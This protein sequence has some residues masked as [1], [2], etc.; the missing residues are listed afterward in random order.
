MQNA[1]PITEKR[2]D[3]IS[4][5]P[6]ARSDIDMLHLQL[7]DDSYKPISI[8]DATTIVTLYFHK[9]SEKTFV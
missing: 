4:Y 5:E 9:S 6:V 1:E 7:A 3:P 2:F 8:Q